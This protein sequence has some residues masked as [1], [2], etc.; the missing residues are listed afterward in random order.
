MV[1]SENHWPAQCSNC[2]C[3]RRPGQQFLE[4]GPCLVRPEGR[5]AG[6]VSEGE[7]GRVV[8]LD[9]VPEPVVDGPPRNAQRARDLGDRRPS[10][11]FQDGQGAAVEPGILGSPQDP[12]ELPSLTRR[13]GQRLLAHT[14]AS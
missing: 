14:I 9:I 6:A 1:S 5:P 7:V 13:Y 2:S 10:G 3:N 8:P 11:H 4:Q 12:L